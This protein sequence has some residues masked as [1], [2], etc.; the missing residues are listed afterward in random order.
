M[1]MTEETT[2]SAAQATNAAGKVAASGWA[3]NDLQTKPAAEA[4]D[5]PAV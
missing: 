5:L 4:I 3:C 2:G 1:T